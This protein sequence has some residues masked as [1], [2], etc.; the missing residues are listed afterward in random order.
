MMSINMSKINLRTYGANDLSAVNL[1]G[2][3]VR[4]V[5]KRQKR[6]APIVATSVMPAVSAPAVPAPAGP[7]PGVVPPPKAYQNIVGLGVGKAALPV[8]KIFYLG[9]LAGAYIGLGAFLAMTV[10]GNVGGIASANPGLQ[11]M[12]LGAFGLPFGLLMVLV[13]GAELFTG[14]TALVT[15][16]V[17]EGKANLGQLVKSWVVSY[18][19]NFLGSLF[20]VY[21]VAATGLLAT[22]GAPKAMAVA[23]T[24]LTFGQAFVRGVLCNWLVCLAIWQASAANDLAGKAVGVWFP[25]SAFVAMGLEHSVANMFIIP[26]GIVL[27]ANVTWGQFLFNN[28]L[29]VTLGNMVAGALLVATSYAFCFGSAAQKK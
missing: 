10:G 13:C 26:M 7:V 6:L 25:I 19:A 24:S 15:A 5:D 4:P 14:N 1:N 2:I 29:P 11:K 27:G 8:W 23:K 9:L 18:G 3:S 20:V 22:A 28:L 12:I 21:M 17:Y 16:A